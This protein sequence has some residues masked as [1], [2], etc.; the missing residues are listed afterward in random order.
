[1]NAIAEL[2]ASGKLAPRPFTVLDIGSQKMQG[3]LADDLF[4]QRLT[5]LDSPALEREQKEIE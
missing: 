1:M 5:I 3:V 4:L 2:P